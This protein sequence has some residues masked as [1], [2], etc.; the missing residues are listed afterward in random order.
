M[1]GKTNQPSKHSDLPLEQSYISQSSTQKILY[2]LQQGCN[3]SKPSKLSRMY[4]HQASISL[5]S[6][7]QMIL[8]PPAHA[9]DDIEHPVAH[10]TT[11]YPSF[12]ELLD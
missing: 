5:E 1:S 10:S 3:G 8:S 12:P 7:E 11:M 4:S 2:L 6:S 9:H